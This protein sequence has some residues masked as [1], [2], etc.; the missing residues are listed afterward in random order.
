MRD[1]AHKVQGVDEAPREVV[2][3]PR[4]AYG[5]GPVRPCWMVLVVDRMPVTLPIS[6]LHLSVITQ[7]D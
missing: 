5:L 7:Q 6:K 2:E 3:R 1:E 4:H